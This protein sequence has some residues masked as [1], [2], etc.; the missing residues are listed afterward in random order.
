MNFFYFLD[1]KACIATLLLHTLLP[2]PRLNRKYKPTISDS[3]EDFMIHVTTINDIHQ[4]IGQCRDTCLRRGIKMQ[5]RILVVG[6]TLKQLSDFYVF[7]D[8]VKYKLPTFTKALDICVKLMFV[9]NLQYPTISK[10]VWIFI[11]EYIYQIPSEVIYPVIRN[12]IK[13][14]EPI[15]INLTP[16]C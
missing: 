2:P 7:C 3:Q 5:P 10:L 12:L 9:F 16:S 11:Q 15:V 1:S 13:Q 4:K 14:L 8:G 6:Q